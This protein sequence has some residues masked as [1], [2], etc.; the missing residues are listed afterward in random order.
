MCPVPGVL[1]QPS[2]EGCQGTAR[3]STQRVKK[4]RG[5]VSGF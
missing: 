1:L 2:H 4:G 5:D 3:F